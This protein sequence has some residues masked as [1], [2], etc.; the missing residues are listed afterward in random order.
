VLLVVSSVW[1]QN[2]QTPAKTAPQQGP[3]PKNL[4]V[5]PDGHVSANQDPLNPEK[6]EVH[7]VKQGE[8]L[9]G[10]ARDV[11]KDWR[12]W[13]QLWEQNE[14]IINPHWIYP[15]DQILIKPITLITEAKPP[16]PTPPPPPE[17]EPEPVPQEPPP[18]PV[19]LPPPPPPPPAPTVFVLEP[20]RP[21]SQI[22]YSDLY[23]SGSVRKAAVPSDLKVV[24]KFDT[25]ASILASETEYVYLSQGTEDGV[26]AGTMYQVVRP[27]TT[28]TN[29]VGRTRADRDLGTHYLDIAQLTVVVAQPDFSLARV[30]HSCADAVD[31]GDIVLPF[32]RL[33]V[34]APPRSRPFNPL[35]TTNSGV[36]GMIVGTKDVMLNWGSTFY[37]SGKIPGVRGGHLDHLAR[38]VAA[39][40]S[41]VYIDIGG[42]SAVKPGDVF[43]AYRDTYVDERLYDLPREVNKIRKTRTAVGELIVV[44]VN[45]RAATAVVSY[46]ADALTLGDSIERR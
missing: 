34:P 30:T 35:M 24:S 28:V 37:A 1:A 4:T 9:S 33:V 6:F 41:I 7:I 29:P 21:V 31:P 22:K 46:A 42:N 26:T 16:E 11:L 45:E 44:R 10:I 43:I 20:Q 14:H 13:P 2:P 27:T 15:N 5:R 17:P 12:L 25:T 36:H 32:Q 18:R 3:P 19:Q 38:G 39:E 40:G 8:T 23:C